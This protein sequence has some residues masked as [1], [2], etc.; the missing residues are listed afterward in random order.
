MAEHNFIHNPRGHANNWSLGHPMGP[1]AF[2]I[3]NTAGHHVIRYN[4][5]IGC[6][7]HRFNDVIESIENGS[8]FGGP[9][10]DTDIH[11]NFL[12][13]SNDD[14]VE[15]D[16][17]QINVRFWNNRQ[18]YSLCGI[19]CAPCRKGPAYI[20][21]NVFGPLG[22][23]RGSCGSTY[24]IGRRHALVAGPGRDPA[25][26]D[27][28]AGAGALERGLRL[29]GR[30]RP[31]PCIRP[32]Q[33]CSPEAAGLDVFDKL[34]DPEN[35]FDF[36]LLGRGGVEAVEGA[37]AHAVKA[38]PTFADEPVG[39]WR[40]AEGSPGIDAGQPLPNINDGFSGKAPDM[41]AFET[42]GAAKAI[43]SRLFGLAASPQW[44]RIDSREAGGA[45]LLITVPAQ[46][47]KRW[48][49]RPNED[50]LK[51]EPKEG[52]CGPDGQTPFRDRDDKGDRRSARSAHD[53]HRRGVSG[54]RAGV[55]KD[56]PRKALGA[57]HRS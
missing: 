27:L 53:P 2:V 6:E 54:F 29:R 51:A 50:W 10:R 47:G 5:C 44:V 30:A 3:A 22:D 52:D 36:D 20:V 28:R 42:G 57:R 35:D 33:T 46:A 45:K 12:A 56:L 4:D 17:G 14:G 9:Y 18:A 7:G 21:R 43:P 19:S 15:L 11:D 39:D 31:V 1:E 41:G 32:K 8:V 38:K 16:G 40:L 49:V 25:Q 37:E 55:C 34:K 26:H 23:D 24:K 13:Y 48:S